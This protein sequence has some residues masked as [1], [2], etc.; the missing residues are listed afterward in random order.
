LAE[1]LDMSEKKLHILSFVGGLVFLSVLAAILLSKGSEIREE[2]E[3]QVQGVLNTSKE[4]LRQAQ[5]VV[6]KVGEITNEIKGVDESNTTENDPTA[7]LSD[8]YDSLWQSV[9]AQ[10]KA[11]VKSRPS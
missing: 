9:E 11:R 8:G 4:I 3:S 10:S 6:V 1:V 2:V 5:F 7:L